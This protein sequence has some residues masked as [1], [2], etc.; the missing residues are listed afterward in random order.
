[1][2]RP[3]LDQDGL[4]KKAIET[5]GKNFAELSPHLQELI[6]S[7]SLLKLSV[8]TLLEIEHIV[9]EFLAGAVQRPGEPKRIKDIWG[10]LVERD[11]GHDFKHIKKDYSEFL[12]QVQPAQTKLLPNGTI[13][14]WSNMRSLY[15]WSLYF[16]RCVLRNTIRYNMAKVIPDETAILGKW[17]GGS[18]MDE[19]VILT[20][21]TT[22]TVSTIS[23][24]EYLRKLVRLHLVNLGKMLETSMGDKKLFVEAKIRQMQR[25]G[26]NKSG[27]L[28]LVIAV[29]RADQLKLSFTPSNR[30]K[31]LI[32]ERISLFYATWFYR[33][34]RKILAVWIKDDPRATNL[35]IDDY[36][37][38]IMT[39]TLPALPK[40]NY[41]HSHVTDTLTVGCAHCEAP[42]PEHQCENCGVAFCG[43]ACW[44]ESEH[45]C[46]INF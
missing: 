1:M 46:V 31:T 19:D 4:D 28:S 32:K 36:L 3:L 40:T 37:K 8:V 27:L 25:L 39:T 17:K 14:Y 20:N 2:K 6:I 45:E 11:F 16:H 34:S 15:F 24:Q 43:T 41:L 5:F 12:N 26:E 35:S 10:Q 7:Q 13:L 42:S 30:G 22:K 33:G 9:P 18:L 21:K 38:F 44:E 29:N 23:S